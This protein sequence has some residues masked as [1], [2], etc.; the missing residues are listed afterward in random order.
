ML[1]I[2]CISVIAWLLVAPLRSYSDDNEFWALVLE[3]AAI[4]IFLGGVQ[5]LL[6]SLI[7]LSFIDGEK[8]MKWSKLAWIAITLPVA[9]LFFQVVLK[10]DGTLSTATDR[11]GITALIVFAAFSWT[12]TGLTWVFFKLKQPKTE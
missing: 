8:V 1:A 12:L 11:D 4:S 10:Q 3:G 9:F 7:P 5:G 2:L 6:F